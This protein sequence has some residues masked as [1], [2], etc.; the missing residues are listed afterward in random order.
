MK[1]KAAVAVA[2]RIFIVGCEVI[3]GMM[4][5]LVGVDGDDDVWG[6]YPNQIS[7]RKWRL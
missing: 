7:H 2:G 3:R 5:E 4:K 1:G 6:F